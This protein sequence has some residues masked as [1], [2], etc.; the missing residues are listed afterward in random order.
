MTTTH[1]STSP[2]TALV[3]G[4]EG[5]DP[6]AIAAAYAPDAK[7]SIVDRDHLPASPLVLAGRDAVASYFRDVCDRD[8]QHTVSMVVADSGGFAFRQDCRYPD[9][10]LVVCITVASVQGG[11]VTQQTIAQSWD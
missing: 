5:R 4:I 11:Q 1:S 9:G 2:L 3:D 8:I 6:E 10:N 7:V